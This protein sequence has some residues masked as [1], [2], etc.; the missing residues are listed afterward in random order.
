[1]EG[2]TVNFPQ[3][4]QS[5]FKPAALVVVGQIFIGLSPVSAAEPVNNACQEMS[6]VYMITITDIEGVYASRGII[7]FAPGGTMIVND[8]RQGG[9]P[10]VY[11]PFSSGQGAWRCEADGAD[12]Y[13][14][15]AMAITF[16]FPGEG[17]RQAFGRI[18]YAGSV[19]RETKRL[20]GKL[21]LRLSPDQDLEVA[22]PVAN[23]G[24]VVEEFGVE[25]ARVELP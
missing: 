21:S 7:T 13:R 3:G 19:N 16:T 2:I 6:G 8:S 4:L 11:E 22:D 15:D 1:M 5:V 23:P 12:A 14:F 9:Q 18:D 24:P 25:G 17:Q 10:G 20:T